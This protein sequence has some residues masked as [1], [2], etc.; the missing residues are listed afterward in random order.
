LKPHFIYKSAFLGVLLFCCYSAVAQNDAL[1][2]WN[3]F[4]FNYYFNKKIFI[5]SEIQVRSQHI[6]D[7]FFY[8][9]LKVGGGYNITDKSSAFLGF[10]NYKT[11]TYP[12]NF[13]KPVTSNE[14]RIWQQFIISAYLGRVKF[15]NRARIEERWIDKDFFMRFRY[16]I[17]SII[18]INHSKLIANTV[19]TSVYD[20]VFFTNE[21]PY[22]IRNRVYGGVGYQFSQTVA[23]QSGFIRQFDYRKTDDG[24]GKN[25]IQLTLIINGGH[26]G[27]EPHHS[28]TD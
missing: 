18:P 2:G 8:H 7:D 22:F 4:N 9:E 25:F 13:E 27:L 1:G 23:L 19:Y 14:Y 20:E 3:I 17:N 16:R 5:Y 21:A 28:D 24:S 6:A 11:Y 10:G 26:P 15:E 12:G